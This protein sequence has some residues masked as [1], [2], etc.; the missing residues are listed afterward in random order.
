LENIKSFFKNKSM[1][2][3]FK[4]LKGKSI[5]FFFPVVLIL[6]IVPLIVRISWIQLDS[7]AA[8]LYGSVLQTELFSQKKSSFLLF[9]SIVLI[10]I[11]IIFFKKI[12]NKKDK[13]ITSILIASAI[14]LLFTF[15]STLFSQHKQYSIYGALGRSEGVITITCYFVILLYSIYTFKTTNDYKY[16]IIP[17]IILV[18][19][20]SFL[21]F[22]QY[23]GKDLINSK[24]G[25]FMVLGHTDTPLNLAYAT[26]KLYGT[27]Y[28]YNYVGSF[29]A[30][31]LPI[32][33]SLTLF[34]KKLIFKI[35]LG[36]SALLSVFLLFGSTSRTG[37]IGVVV[38]AFFGVIIF[39]RTIFKKWKILLICFLSIIVMIIGLNFATKG[40][41]FE[42]IPGLLRDASSIFKDTSDFDYKEHIPVKDIKNIGNDIEV[43]FPDKTL[44]ISYENNNYI[45]K[46]SNNEVIPYIKG[47]DTSKNSR[48]N[49][50]TTNDVKFNAIS[51]NSK[52]ISSKSKV[53]DYIYLNING[54]PM[55]MF[56]LKEDGNIHLININSSVNID[57]DYPETISFLNGKELL[58]SS[59][60]YIWSRSI[61]L[62][63]NNLLLGSGPDTFIFQFPQNDLFGKYYAYDNPNI[64]VDKPHNIYLQIA[65][66]EGLI[67]LLAFLAIILIYSIDSMKLYALRR[68]YSKTHV[69]G[70]ATFLGV[71]GYLF[72]GL[73]NDSVISIA[74][75]FWI[76]LGVGIALN[77]IA[78]KEVNKSINWFC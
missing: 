48:E 26:G 52:K 67:A 14:F 36:T 19:I 1:S 5:G 17:I 9:F 77:Y 56:R 20:T 44:R 25:L 63:K 27:F 2:F 16:V 64:I 18:A 69:L 35:I 61:P 54:Q 8:D 65:L 70:T 75:I 37:I 57:V 4:F 30:I 55:F 32:L 59:R 45:F 78:R 66:N 31:V 51:F 50:Y 7:D 33:L 24:L 22:F 3:P 28:H 21:G 72:T 53:P 40:V 23:V 29:V 68:E 13:I 43:I 60:G 58:G 6:T 74:P 38:S 71:I 11:S 73:F 12:F 34:E 41:I 62:I 76:I 10:L 39:A 15:L 49:T 47:G 46:D 42:R